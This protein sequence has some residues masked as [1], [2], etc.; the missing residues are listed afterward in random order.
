MLYHYC[1]VDSFFK[2]IE[3]KSLWLSDI[4]HMNDYREV[5]WAHEKILRS[6]RQLDKDHGEGHAQLLLE[7]LR[8][9]HTMHFICSF[10]CE[11]DL[12]SQWR[13]Y[14]MDG[15][16]IAIG[17]TDHGLPRAAHLPHCNA[18]PELS[19]GIYEVVYDEANQQAAIDS[20]LEKFMDR[21]NTEDGAERGEALPGA[22][23]ILGG[24]SVL[25]KN[26]AFA[27]ER[28][29]RLVHTPLIT[30]GPG[31]IRVDS[32]ISQLRHR[33][34]GGRI[35]PYFEYDF[36]SKLDDDLIAEV[37]IGPKCPVTQYDL[38]MFLQ[39]NGIRNAQI[40]RSSASYR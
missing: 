34:S 14:A 21:M 8:L 26:P 10:S 24:T 3:S 12:L 36:S 9:N 40:K 33:V 11:G 1:S 23:Y 4:N 38:E 22:V 18:N 17:F 32:A 7:H 20:T 27:E 19:V 39:V 30:D 2:I 5:R 28:E 35:V 29:W 37:V 6:L 25:F 31:G 13:A 16:G 15:T